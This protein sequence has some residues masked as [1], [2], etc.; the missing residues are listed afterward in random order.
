M[1]IEKTEI[2]ITFRISYLC[3][4]QLPTQTLITDIV[5]DCEGSFRE[6]GEEQSGVLGGMNAERC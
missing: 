1:K 2:W 6:F 3:Q 4:C 5:F